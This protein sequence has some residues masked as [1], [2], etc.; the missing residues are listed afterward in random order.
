MFDQLG[1]SLGNV[2][3]NL[4]KHG[5]LREQDIQNACEEIKR[6]LLEADVA[7]GAVKE[8]F[9]NF[10]PRIEELTKELAE[11][12]NPA[13]ELIERAQSAL[14][15]LLGEGSQ[16]PLR[17]N[18]GAAGL[19]SPP[20]ILIVGLQG[21]GKTTTSVKL[22]ANLQKQGHKTLLVSLDFSRPAAEEQ[23]ATLAQRANLPILRQAEVS[24]NNGK[25]SQEKAI[26]LAKLAKKSATSKNALLICDTA[27]RMQVDQEAMAEIA[28]IEKILAPRET[29]LVADAMLGQEAANV[30][31]KFNKLLKISGI[32]LTRLEGDARAGAALSMMSATK[33]PIRFAGVG[34]NINDLQAFEPNALASRIL[35]RGDLKGLVEKIQ[36]AIPEVTQ[37]EKQDGK[38]GGK[39]GGKAIVTGK[40]DLNA[41]KKQIQQIRKAGGLHALAKHLPKAMQDKINDARSKSMVDEKKL[42]RQEVIIDS[43][44]P[45]ERRSPKI[46]HASRK[47]RIAAGASA[48]I[49]E[50]N[51][52]LKN[53]LQSAKAMKNMARWD[54]KMLQRNVGSLF[55]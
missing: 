23:L 49:V 7:L 16:Q 53:H 9:E 41:H 27:G 11:A 17:I 47:K 36:K 10:A 52:L 32:I 8:F 55:R 24:K 30:A 31:S 4:R 39:Q 12:I 21:S 34:E 29:F 28:E 45:A 46:I 19:A 20:V 38:Q 42:K 54:E 22:A 2:F 48:S 33:K 40:F 13:E 25:N 44:T 50:V 43:M 3:A 5:S 15:L 18:T 1:Q 37:G 6:A 51:R 26:A 35:G 14:A